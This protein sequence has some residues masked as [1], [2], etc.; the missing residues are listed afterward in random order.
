MQLVDDNVPLNLTISPVLPGAPA[1]RPAGGIIASDD[2][3]VV[4]PGTTP[5]YNRANPLLR[6]LDLAAQS[7]LSA[8]RELY[9]DASLQML[10]PFSHLELYGPQGAGYQVTD[11]RRQDDKTDFQ[12]QNIASFVTTDAYLSRGWVSAG[13]WTGPFLK[14]SYSGDPDSP[15]GAAAG[16]P[17]GESIR[18]WLRVAGTA[19]ASA[20]RVPYNDATARYE[21]EIWGYPGSD[22][23]KLLGDKGRGALQRGELVCRPDLVQGTWADFQRDGLDGR[24]VLEVAPGHAMHPLLPLHVEVAWADD[25]ERTWDSLGGANYQYEFN[26]TLRGWNSYL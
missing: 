14:L 22:L 19:T 2:V 21:L 10:I 1:P 12:K 23:D 20:L 4:P 25:A 9:L 13:D 3:R 11:P 15:L 8:E 18:V 6:L 16:R 7:H 24:N 17:L 26:M 5:N